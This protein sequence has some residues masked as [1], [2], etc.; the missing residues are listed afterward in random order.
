VLVK[1]PSLHNKKE[2]KDSPKIKSKRW[3]GRVC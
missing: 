1:I 2:K 3:N